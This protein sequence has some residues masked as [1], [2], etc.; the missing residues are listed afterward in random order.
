MTYAYG[1]IGK[2]LRH[3]FSKDIHE[4]LADYDYELIELGEDELSSFFEK[5]EF[6]AINVTIPYKESVLPFLDCIDAEALAIGAVNTVVNRDGRL[7]GYNTDI[8]GM[9][10]LLRHAGLSVKDKKV[11]ILG[12]GGTSKTAVA[13]CR[14]DGARE[15]LRISRTAR[16]GALTYEQA[17]AQHADAELIINTTPVGMFPNNFDS[18]I[19]I[20]AF[21]RLCGVIDAVYNPLRTPLILEARRRGIAAE[22]GLFMLVAQGV[23]ASELFLDTVY[24]EEVEERVFRRVLAKKESIVLIGM[25]AS[26]KSTVGKLL[27]ERLSRELIDTD[28]RIEDIRGASA[29]DILASEGEPV[30][31]AYETDAIRSTAPL[32]GAVVA[33]GGGA[34]LRDENVD[35]LRQNGRLYFLDRSLHL[36]TPTAD[37]PLSR[38]RDMLKARYEERHGR[39]LACADVH[40]YAD[41]T[42]DEVAGLI[43]GDFLS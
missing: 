32:S 29:A 22:G 16:E 18:P 3:S 31:R 17:Y 13:L 28:A 40:V 25:P 23:R 21:P 38:D 12:T 37:R 24:G 42:P 4:A 34:I 10:A 15:V 41:G 43:E 2:T 33:T 9:R 7:Y 35:L 11:L 14:A 8:Y 30:F 36:L 5:K 27:S 20:D 6:R 1:C 26:G 19:R 39:Y